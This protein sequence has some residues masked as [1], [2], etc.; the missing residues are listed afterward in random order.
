MDDSGK[1]MKESAMRASRRKIADE[2]L[3]SRIEKL[4]CKGECQ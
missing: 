4:N 3:K 2:L 1:I